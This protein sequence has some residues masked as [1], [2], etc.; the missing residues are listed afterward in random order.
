MKDEHEPGTSAPQ[1]SKCRKTFVKHET[2]W[3]MDGNLLLQIGDTRFKVFK[4]RLVSESTWF[5]ALIEQRG[6][7]VPEEPYMDPDVIDRV[8]ATVQEME[9]LDLFYLDE[10]NYPKH[11]KSFS[12]FLTAMSNG[13]WCYSLLLHGRSVC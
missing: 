8:L 4:S 11:L 2:H 10:E 5:A 13:M 6:G 12:L 1:P 7:V 9:G 3:A